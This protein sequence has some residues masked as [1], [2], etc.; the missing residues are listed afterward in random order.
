M[1]QHAR[2]GC[3]VMIVIC[4]AACGLAP[5]DPT[6]VARDLVL[7]SKPQYDVVGR[8]VSYGDAILIPLRV[9]TK[10]FS[11]IDGEGAL[12]LVEVFTAIQTPA[13]D[14]AIGQMANGPA[15]MPKLV[16]AAV[17]GRRGRPIERMRPELVRIAAGAWTEEEKKDATLGEGNER[18]VLINQLWL[19]QRLAI[20]AL[21]QPRGVEEIGKLAGLLSDKNSS[22][23]HAAVCDALGLAGGPESVT[24]LQ[25]AMRDSRFEDTPAAFRALVKLGDRQAVPLAISRI[26][27]ESEKYTGGWLVPELEKVTGVHL[28]ADRAKWEAWWQSRSTAA[29]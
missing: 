14:Q 17:L 26:D 27:P 7:T 21:G 22:P 29:S 4:G 20:A 13:A 3:A 28:G 5:N 23:L 6:R 8:A 24:A 19:Y 11:S 25:A 9:V 18:G 12:R 10:D 16:A 15:L 1:S 2:W